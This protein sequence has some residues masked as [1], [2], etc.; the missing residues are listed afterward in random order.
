MRHRLYNILRI[1]PPDC[2][3]SNPL[4]QR[5]VVNYELPKYPGWARDK[6]IEAEVVIRFFVSQ[7]GHVR[8]RL[9]LERTSGYPELDKIS[10]KALKKWL[11]A[12][13]PAER[14]Q[15]GDQWGIIT[16]RFRLK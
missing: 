14:A 12:A 2:Q 5:K 13:L 16:F 7:E 4:A 8:D 9:I 1:G 15:E 6:G 11:F 3:G 10:M